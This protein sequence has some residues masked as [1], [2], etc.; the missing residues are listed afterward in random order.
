MDFFPNYPEKIMPNRVFFWNVR[1]VCDQKKI[2][3]PDIIQIFNTISP[4]QVK[5]MKQELISAKYGDDK[6]KESSTIEVLPEFKKYFEATKFITSKFFLLKMTI[7]FK[8]S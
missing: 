6:D 8:N 1:S 5:K 2:I 3:G 4:E 7:D